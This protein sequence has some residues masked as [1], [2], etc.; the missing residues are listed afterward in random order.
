ML[1]CRSL[2]L[3]ASGGNGVEEAHHRLVGPVFRIVVDLGI[4]ARAY[5]VVN[6]F[7]LTEVVPELLDLFG[8]NI[9]GAATLRRL[10]RHDG[11][12]LAGRLGAFEASVEPSL[13]CPVAPPGGV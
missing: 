7:A 10:L 9:V 3:N 12:L 6:S 13:A 5:G 8:R 1:P 2:R 11:Y 4:T